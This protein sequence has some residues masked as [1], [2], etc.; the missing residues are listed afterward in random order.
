MKLKNEDIDV[1]SKIY[2]SAF[3]KERTFFHEN[4]SAEIHAFLRENYFGDNLMLRLKLL[5]NLLDYDSSNLK[6]KKKRKELAQKSEE[7]N[8]YLSQIQV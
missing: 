6:D 4:E 3:G 5:V 1:L 2:I 7:L 8:K